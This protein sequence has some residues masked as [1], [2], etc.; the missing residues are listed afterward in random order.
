M[1]ENEVQ[2]Q[3]KDNGVLKCLWR[4]VRFGEKGVSSYMNKEK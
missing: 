4:I 2:K 1:V 3:S